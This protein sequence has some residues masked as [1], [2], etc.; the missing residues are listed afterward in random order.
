MYS[1]FAKDMSTTYASGAKKPP[2]YQ[3]SNVQGALKSAA[4]GVGI[5]G[6]AAGFLGDVVGEAGI[7]VGRAVLDD[8]AEQEVNNFISSIASSKAVQDTSKAYQGFEEK[9]PYAS[10]FVSGGANILGLTGT[11]A[12]GTAA[13]TAGKSAAKSAAKATAKAAMRGIEYASPSVASGI[14]T[15]ATIASDIAKSAGSQLFAMSPQTIKAIVDGNVSKQALESLD[16]VSLENRVSQGLNTAI[17]DLSGLGQEYADL[18]NQVVDI[19]VGRS[20]RGVTISEPITKALN[21]FGMSVDQSGK[22]IR[23]TNSTPLTQQT[24]NRIYDFAQ[25]Y[26]KTGKL[27]SK[28]FLNIRK[29][30]DNIIDWNST[31]ADVADSFVKAVRGNYDEI[32]KKQIKGLAEKDASFSEV[33]QDLKNLKRQLVGP[34]GQMKDNASS[35]IA[36]LTNKGNEKKLARLEK[37]VPGIT[38]E[39]MV[40]KAVEDIANASGIK[41]GTYTRGIV[42]AAATLANP[43]AGVLAFIATHPSVVVPILRAYG[44]GKRAVQAVVDSI[45]GKITTGKQLNKTE[46]KV[47]SDAILDAKL[48]QTPPESGGRVMRSSFGMPD[49]KGNPTKGIRG[50]ME[51][52]QDIPSVR[53]YT[54]T[55]ALTTTLLKELEGKTT[56]S[57][58]YLLDATNRPEIKQVEKDLIRSILNE[59]DGKTINAEEFANRVK[60][61]LLPLERKTNAIYEKKRVEGRGGNRITT[62]HTELSDSL[63]VARYEHI[64]LPDELRGDISN[65]AEVIYESPIKTSAGGTH[66]AGATENYFGHT[67]TED[68]ADGITRRVIEVQS[69]LYQKGNLDIEKMRSQGLSTA[70]MLKGKTEGVPTARTREL[71]KLSQYN[72]PTAHFRMIREELKQASVDGKEKLLFPTGETA[73]KI[74]GLGQ[75]ENNFRLLYEDIEVPSGIRPS[76]STKLTQ[77]NIEVGARISQGQPYDNESFNQWIITDVLGDGKFK[78]IPKDRIGLRE[79]E[80]LLNGENINDIKNSRFVEEFDISGKVDKN[81]PIYKFYEKD[82]QK[83]L[84]RIRPETKQVT[85][86][87]GITWYEVP[88]RKEDKYLPVE[89]FGLVAAPAITPLVQGRKKKEK[90][91]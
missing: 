32:G 22:I 44:Q 75:S 51:A 74:E 13:Q 33:A 52:Q 41:V 84:K 89:A 1:T 37:Y 68:M 43:L 62:Q 86:K 26:G 31:D 69:D 67:R 39:I 61:E 88:V 14:K 36:N 91:K 19:P 54:E 47:F 25:T 90:K 49:D 78:A 35:V 5:V 28:E 6:Q 42:T 27:S 85:D 53:P 34:G 48:Y 63:D 81:N 80:G 82:V 58:Q 76:G 21:D 57:K 87:Q 45:I 83:Y 2:E 30:L 9:N 56:V 55:G 24:I 10:A 71:S 3:T 17:D 40:L 4:T 12:V 38:E 73:M 50:R 66:F 72:D 11:G 29:A 59:F 20:Y 8:K 18:Y 7:A 23:G 65:Y 46:F 15:G 70:E 64:T 16:R 77:E 79:A 60:V